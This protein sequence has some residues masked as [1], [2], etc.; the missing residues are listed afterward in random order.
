MRLTYSAVVVLAATV[1]HQGFAQ[2]RGGAFT[3]EQVRD[4]PFPTELSAAARAPRIAWAFNERGLRNIYGAE[5]PAWTARKLTAFDRD[6]GQ[7]LTSVNLSADGARVAFVRG[8]D[9]DAN[10]DTE[11]PV[12]PASSPLPQRVQVWSASFDGRAPVLIGDGDHPA[13]SPS[14]SMI[15]FERERNIWIAPADG[16]APPRRLFAARGDNRA[17]TWSPDGTKLAFV[18]DR[19][20]HSFIGVYVN[21]STPILWLAPSSGRDVSPRWSPDG[22]RIAFM[23]R[24]GIGG[25]P[26]SILNRPPQAWS[27]WTADAS[28]GVGREAWRSPRTARGFPPAID[29][30][31]NLMYGV[32]GRVAFLSYMD[33]WPHL[34]SVADT[35]GNALLLTPGNY[36]VE[37]VRISP[38]RRYIVYSANAGTGTDDI[39]RRHLMRVPIDRAM[40]QQVTS[41]DGLEFSP[42]VTGDTATI[43]LLS[44]TALRPILPAVVPAAGG[45][46]RLIAAD[47]LNAAFP[48][49]LIVPRAVTFTSSDGLTIRGQLF[50]RP[51]GAT[52][53]AAIVFA[54]GGPARQMLLGWHYMEYYSGTYAMN[55]FLA[56]QGYVVLSV[57]FRLGIGYGFDFHM[58]PNS[59]YRGGSEY[60]DVRAAGEFL[61]AMP[62]VDG[63]RIGVYGGSYGGYLTAMSLTRS[64]D[65]FAAGV[66]IHGVADFTQDGASRIGGTVWRYEPGDRAEAAKVAFNS[67]PVAYVDAWKAPVLFIHGDDDRSVRFSHTIDLEKRLADRGVAYEELIIPD[68][69]HHWMKWTNFVK[70]FAATAEFFDRKIGPARPGAVR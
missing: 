34:Y 25:P 17:P 52:K 9:H 61:K 10:W 18:G 37:T 46:P 27:V 57:N 26:E 1:S 29:G 48:K 33:G 66:D 3:Y 44:A 11:T 22:K 39:D 28:T 41:G 64:A 62:Q 45:A 36:M 2:T 38:D 23:R 49:D 63:A 68:D 58:P 43:A 7:E 53:K 14:G 20:D 6:D 31:V 42:V 51:G 50:E 32:G 70:V 47:R 4:Y 5:A 8:G 19:G 12:N 55:Q 65:L 60:L 56:S 54:H 69:T 21:D 24:P 13:L 16:S 30:G 59:Y 67:S 35:G 40:P 15:A